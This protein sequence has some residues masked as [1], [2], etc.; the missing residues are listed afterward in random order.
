MND[1]LRK[2]VR[3]LKALQHISYKEFAEY[4]EIKTDSFYCWL[5]G[6]YDLGFEKQQKLKEIIEI[7]KE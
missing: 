6:Y 3:L 7:I 2:E 5:N 4:I 1:L